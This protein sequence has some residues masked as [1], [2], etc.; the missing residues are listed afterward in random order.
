LAWIAL[1]IFFY[2]SNAHLCS[3]QF[4]TVRSGLAVGALF[5]LAT[6]IRFILLRV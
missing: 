5:L 2:E 3:D 1:M 4:R 6:L